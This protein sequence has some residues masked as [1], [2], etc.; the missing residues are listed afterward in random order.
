MVPVPENSVIGSKPS[1]NII[2]NGEEGASS[3]SFA[4]SGLEQTDK[5]GR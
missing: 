4:A 3:D 5:R 1:P 2:T